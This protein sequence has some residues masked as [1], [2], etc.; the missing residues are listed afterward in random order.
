MAVPADVERI[1]RLA[2]AAAL[3][4]GDIDYDQFKKV[5]DWIDVNR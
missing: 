1:I 2:L 4:T 3:V 5:K